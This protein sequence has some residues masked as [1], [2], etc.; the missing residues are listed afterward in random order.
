MKSRLET[1]KSILKGIVGFLSIARYLP[2]IGKWRDVAM[3]L[4]ALLG[5][6]ITVIE[7]CDSN[8]PSQP[9]VQTI[10]TQPTSTPTPIPTHTPSPTPSPKPTPLIIVPE[11]IAAG[12]PFLVKVTAKFDYGV[13]LYADRFEL[14]TL[15]EE[16]KTRHFTCTVTLW[17]A[18]KRKIWA[19]LPSGKVEAWI[20]VQ[21]AGP[22]TQ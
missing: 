14:C 17:T 5:G 2:F 13:K 15:G 10:P 7:K 18:G 19:N 9:P 4:A 12:E 1:L 8:H 22:R 20:H 6:L 11:R 3:A 16:Y 21:K